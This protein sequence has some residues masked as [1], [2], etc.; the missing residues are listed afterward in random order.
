MIRLRIQTNTNRCIKNGIKSKRAYFPMY[1]Q[2]TN[3]KTCSRIIFLFFLNQ[4]IKECNNNN[5]V[6]IF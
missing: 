5:E 3:N 6:L 1:S 2:I 4:I